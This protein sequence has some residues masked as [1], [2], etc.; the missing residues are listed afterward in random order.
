MNNEL[1]PIEELTRKKIKKEIRK[2]IYSKTIHVFLAITIIIT[3][4]YYGTSFLLNHTNYNPFNEDELIENNHTY[5][6]FDFLMATYIPM[7]Y[8]GKSYYP[9]SPTQK[10]GFGKYN[11]NATIQDSWDAKQSPN[12][13]FTITRSNITYQTTTDILKYN[14][15]EFYDLDGDEDY[16]KT[17]QSTIDSFNLSDIK[18]LPDSSIIDVS[19]SFKQPKTLDETATLINT[20]PKSKFIFLAKR[21]EILGISLQ[22]INY[23]KLSAFTISKYPG[24]NLPKQLTGEAILTSHKTQ[25]KLLNDR[26]YFMNLMLN[27]VSDGSASFDLQAAN[28]KLKNDNVEVTGIRGYLQK[29]DLLKILEQ[30][31][32]IYTHINN[33]KYSK[34]QK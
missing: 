8:P 19:L 24:L 33:V 31:E 34:Y 16:K 27:F 21:G 14:L 20:Y 11:I 10:E 17:M 28:K 3:S 2:E 30:D 13:T 18:Q 15:F 7:A 9:S 29:A 5:T 12:T 4:L 6:G 23:F 25:I 26:K 22:N 32:I 1:N